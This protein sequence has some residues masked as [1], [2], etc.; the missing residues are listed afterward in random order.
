MET[1]HLLI[2]LKSMEMIKGNHNMKKYYLIKI[3]YKGE[4]FYVIWYEDEEDGFMVKEQKLVLFH[5]IEKAKSFSEKEK[6]FLE[7]EIVSYDFTKVI[8]TADH[9][10]N[11]EDCRILFNTWNFFSDLAR[12][13]NEKFIGDLDE[14]QIL[15]IYDKLFYGCNLEVINEGEEEYSP[16]FDDD[17]RKKMI[18]ILENGLSLLDRGDLRY[19]QRN[20]RQFL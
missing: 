3:I 15:K 9:I 11:S 13:L 18:L 10:S 16:C 2:Q 19:A 20:N 6:I 17:E 8:D 1:E 5:S 14:E 4:I 12:T 7:K